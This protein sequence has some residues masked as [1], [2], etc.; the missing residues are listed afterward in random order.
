VLFRVISWIEFC[1]HRRSTN[2]HELHEVRR[3]GFVLFRV[4]S[5]MPFLPVE[6]TARVIFD[7]KNGKVEL[8]YKRLYWMIAFQRSA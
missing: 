3:R 1:R 4:I 6:I 8:P 2:S 5:W 7:F